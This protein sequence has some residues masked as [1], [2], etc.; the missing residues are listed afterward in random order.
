MVSGFADV[1]LTVQETFISK[2]SKSLKQSILFLLYEKMKDLIKTK[3][4]KTKKTD[5]YKR[6]KQCNEKNGKH[7]H[8]LV[9]V[10]II[11]MQS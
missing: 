2:F 1:V 4:N 3:E 11:R 9:F 5:E 6:G 7:T 10:T 8:G